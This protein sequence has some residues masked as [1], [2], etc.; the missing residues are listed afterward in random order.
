MR[1][2][3]LLHLI[4]MMEKERLTVPEGFQSG[5]ILEKGKV[6]EVRKEKRAGNR[7][8]LLSNHV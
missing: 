2:L 3:A 6:R 5:D 8:G 1:L 4:M 7:N